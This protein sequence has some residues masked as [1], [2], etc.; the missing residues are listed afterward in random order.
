[1]R[2]NA[3]HMTSVQ[4]L[5]ELF[6]VPKTGFDVSV[7]QQQLHK[8]HASQHRIDEGL[9]KHIVFLQG[10]GIAGVSHHDLLFSKAAEPV[11]PAGPDDKDLNVTWE[12]RNPAYAGHRSKPASKHD[13]V[14][15]IWEDTETLGK[16]FFTT[17]N[18][19]LQAQSEHDSM[20]K[21]L[22]LRGKLN[23]LWKTFNDKVRFHLPIRS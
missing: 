20:V 13:S 16:G 9:Q 14:T 3:S 12:P 17:A 18:A 1:M 15:H 10:L 22:F 4:E 5:R 8:E 23:R 6:Q 2:G 19:Q 7:T 21:V 11:P